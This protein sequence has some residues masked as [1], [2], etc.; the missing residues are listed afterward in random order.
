[1]GWEIG[2]ACIVIHYIHHKAVIQGPDVVL[3][4]VV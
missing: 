3:Y 1:M 4:I 2:A